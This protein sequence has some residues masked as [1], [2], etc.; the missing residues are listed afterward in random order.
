MQVISAKIN[1]NL[2]AWDGPLGDGVESPEMGKRRGRVRKPVG[3][4]AGRGRNE[5]IW[6][7]E[8]GSGSESGRE[9]GT[10]GTG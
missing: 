2:S 5:T 10:R 9:H 7:K 1:P 3:C 8:R 4:I 6:R